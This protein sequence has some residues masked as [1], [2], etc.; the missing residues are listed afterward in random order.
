MKFMKYLFAFALAVAFFANAS[1]SHAQASVQYLATGSSAL[2]LEL[3]QAAAALSDTGCYW[4]KKTPPSGTTISARDTRVGSPG[5]DETG[6]IWVTWGPG[7]GSC[8]TPAGTYHV[9]AEMNL[10][11]VLGDR[12]FFMVDSGGVAGCTQIITVPGSVGG[13]GG[14]AGDSPSQLGSGYTDTIIPQPVVTALNNQRIF[15]AATDVRP[16]DAKFASAR[17]FTPCG[18]GIYRNPYIQ[19]SYLTYGL[20][21]QTGTTGVGVTLLDSTGK[22]F[23]VIDFNISGNDPITG[24]ALPSNVANYTVSTVGAQPIV[25]V[26]SPVPTAGTGIGAANDIPSSTLAE[27]LLGGY[28]RSTDLIGPTSANPVTVYIREPLSGTYNTM[29]FSNPNSNQF[30]SQQDLF[31]CSGSTFATNPMSIPTAFGAISGASKQRVIGTG[32]MVAALKAHS[33]GDSLGYFFWSAANGS[34]FAPTTAKYLTVSGVDPLADS[35]SVTN[36]VLPG[37]GTVPLSAVTFKNLNAGDYSIWSAL[38]L[39]SVSPTPAGVTAVINGA[40]TLSSTQNDFIPLSNLKVWKS[41]FNLLGL[42]ITNNS[43]GNTVNPATPGDLCGITPLSSNPEGGG[44]AGGATMSV[45]GNHDFCSDFST[46]EGITD[47]NN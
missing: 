2:F 7:S 17:M 31:N 8:A 47:K 40:Q 5:T 28:G 3:G 16:E 1:V 4:T 20:G 41:H 39:V 29:E 14:T 26:V 13:V 35:Y 46:P 32:N 21:Y 44:D 19:T 34:G 30:K 6:A 10:D 33:A 12:C 43:N 11:S 23:H 38:R 25:V 22:Q 15:V 42:G 36:G 45:Q 37:N 18:Q 24:S 9:Y 27:F